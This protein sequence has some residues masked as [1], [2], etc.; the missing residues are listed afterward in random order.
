MGK[1][2]TMELEVAQE[3]ARALG[4]I[5]LERLSPEMRI[6]RKSAKELVTSV[7]VECQQAL[8]ELLGKKF[9]YYILSEEKRIN[10]QIDTDY[11]WIVDPVDGTHNYVAHLP[12]FGVS[13]ALATKTEFILGVIYMP[14]LQEM[15]H[16]LKGNGAFLNGEKISVS[17]N[18]HLE[19][20]MITYDNQ[21][22]LNQY[23]FDRYREISQQCFTT[24]ILGSAVYDLCL[25]SSG[26]IDARIW[27]HTKVFDFAAGVVI[28]REAGGRITDFQGKDVTL[29][30]KELIASNGHIHDDLIKIVTGAKTKKG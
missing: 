22:H 19:K 7:D 27:N 29:E 10:E 12:L 26:R 23:A 28:I 15:C 5:Q 14:Y 20:S 17:P 21:F 9:P 25:V 13:I 3:A 24:R 18:P 4:K 1:N 8:P 6:I 2:F 11:F 30:S 16:A